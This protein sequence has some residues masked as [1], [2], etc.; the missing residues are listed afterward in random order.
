MT[1]LAGLSPHARVVRYIDE[2]APEWRAAVF[3]GG[4]G[5]DVNSF[6][7]T[8]FARDVRE[9]LRLRFVSVERNGFGMTPFDPS[10]GYED[11]VDDV[12]GVLDALEIRRFAVVA[13]SG[14]APF[15]AAL[16]ARVPHRVLSLHLAAGVAGPLVAHCGTAR[17]L[18][19]QPSGLSADPALAHEWELVSSEPLADLSGLYAPSYLY[20]GVDDDVLPPSVHVREWRRVLPRIAALRA[21]P[22]EGHDVPYR[23]WEQI[24]GDVAGVGGA[25]Q[26]LSV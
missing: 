17:V 20:W 24:L 19:A 10:L 26:P 2:G 15:A 14:G 22:G 11:A 6:Y 25:R 5:T 23:H 16:A 3:F 18:Y 4:L 9:R 1:A 12:T 13:I 21:Y 8:E 7:E